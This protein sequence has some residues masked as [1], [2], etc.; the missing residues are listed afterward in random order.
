MTVAFIRTGS[1]AARPEHAAAR[2]IASDEVLI[3]RIAGGDQLA[4]QTLFVRHRVALYRWPTAPRR[5]R[6][7][8]R[9]PLERRVS[10]RLAPWRALRPPGK[11]AFVRRLGEGSRSARRCDK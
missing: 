4:M 3:R 11:C 5:R 9:R 8:G 7:L 1:A 6:G 10:R 2:E